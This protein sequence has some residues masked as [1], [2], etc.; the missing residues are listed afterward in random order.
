MIQWTCLK[1][2]DDYQTDNH[3]DGYIDTGQDGLVICYEL[4][5]T[6]EKSNFVIKDKVKCYQSTCIFR[7]WHKLCGASCIVSTA[8]DMAEWM[9]FNLQ[10]GKNSVGTRKMDTSTFEMA[11]TPW[12]RMQS[13]FIEDYFKMPDVSHCLGNCC[14]SIWKFL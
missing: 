12:N 1:I 6:K 13:A 8:N 2:I 5:A 9:I 11:H 10:Q 4:Q 14:I 3:T 7:Q